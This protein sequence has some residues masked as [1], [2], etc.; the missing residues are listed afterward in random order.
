MRIVL[1]GNCFKPLTYNVVKGL[2]DDGRYSLELVVLKKTIPA[3]PKSILYRAFNFIKTN[4]V[5]ALIKKIAN[6]VNHKSER[7]QTNVAELCQSKGVAY[8]TDPNLNA[9]RV[10]Q[11]IREIAPDFIVLAGSSVIKAHIFS[12]AKRCTINIHR[13]LLPKYAGLQAIF[14]ALYHDEPEIGATVHTVNEGI[15]SGDIIVQRVR[16]IEFDDDI[17]TLTNWYLNVASSMMIEALDIVSSAEPQLIK[18]NR[19]QRTYFSRPTA[20]QQRE[21]RIK[22]KQK[23]QKYD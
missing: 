6:T 9:D 7:V 22:L 3:K 1:I 8:H 10:A 19:S 15:D 4:N 17:D 21:L 12:L 18:Q 13:S 16:N 5:S 2:L 23:R 14:W 11:L 20:D